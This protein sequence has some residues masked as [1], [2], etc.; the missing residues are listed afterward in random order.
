MASWRDPPRAVSES[1]VT[2]A[3]ITHTRML[4]TNDARPR[5]QPRC[6]SAATAGRNVAARVTATTIGPITTGNCDKMATASPMKPTATSS[7]QLHCARRSSQIG[8]SPL[9]DTLTVAGRPEHIERGPRNGHHDGD[10]RHRDEHPGKAAQREPDQE[11]EEDDGRVQ[12]EGAVGQ[13]PR[14]PSLL[15]DLQDDNDQQEQQRGR[16]SAQRKTGEHQDPCHEE[17]ADVGDEPGRQHEHRK[18][19][20]ERHADQGQDDEAQQGIHGRDHSGSAHVAARSVH[21][22]L[23]GIPDPIA[24]PAAK[25]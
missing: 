10:R 25:L 9:A 8:M 20:R 6:S 22:L 3:T 7:R 23:A 1:D 14:Q 21:R 2:T 17:A 18:W 4:T 11:G 19:P 12:F 13:E 16:H 15:D 5:V 24:L